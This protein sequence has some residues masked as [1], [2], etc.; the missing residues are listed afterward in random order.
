MDTCAAP[1][2]SAATTFTHLREKNMSVKALIAG[3][4]GSTAAKLDKGHIA[5]K[6]EDDT[7]ED[8]LV[9]GLR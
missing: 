2:S 5:V 1:S 6:D 8:L 4:M 9:A 3:A 7:A